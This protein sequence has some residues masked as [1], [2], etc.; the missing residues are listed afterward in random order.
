M[1]EL[2]KWKQCKETAVIQQSRPRRTLPLFTHP[3]FRSNKN[4]SVLKAV[5]TMQRNCSIPAVL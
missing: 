5:E 4:M 2:K 3:T 1:S